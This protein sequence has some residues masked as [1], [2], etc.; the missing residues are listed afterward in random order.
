[1]R[2]ASEGGKPQISET[3]PHARIGRLLPVVTLYL[4]GLAACGSQTAPPPSIPADA[5]QGLNASSTRVLAAIDVAD[6]ALAPDGL[7]SIL[8]DAEYTSG[9]ERTFT[10][11]GDIR[12]V[13]VRVLKF[14]SASG[15]QSYLDWLDGHAGEILG[16]VDLS[17]TIGIDG[18]KAP[19]YGHLPGGC[20]PKEVPVYLTGWSDGAKIVTV[21]V[22]G[23]AADERA[24][25][26]LA[27]E[28]HRA[29]GGSEGDA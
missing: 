28:V 14:R 16:T 3:A 22:L 7:T 5:V 15:G 12:S 11:G 9:A 27:A 6:D 18:A 26:S 4:A 8:E 23:P 17:T 13:T 21:L 24:V 20:C 25:A 2:D 29:T 1:M 19:V 10:G